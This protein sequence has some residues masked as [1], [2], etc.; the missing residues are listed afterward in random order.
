[1]KAKIELHRAGI[2]KLF[3]LLALAYGT[4]AGLS[5]DLSGNRRE[6]SE[7]GCPVPKARAIRATG[8]SELPV[9]D[10]IVEANLNLQWVV[11]G[12]VNPTLTLTRGRTYQFDLTA[13]G[14][15]H[16][17]IINSIANSQFGTVYSGPACGQVL[18]FTP[19]F[20][21]PSTIY[22]HCEVHAG[23]GGTIQLVNCSGDLNN[24]FTVNSTDFG[25]FV[26]AF[27]TNCAGCPADLNGSGSVNSTDFGLFVGAF[28]NTCNWQ[29]C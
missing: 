4:G 3:V 29:G 23:M 16:P 7:T 8:S 24:D 18:S 17:W 6:P 1:M 14:D 13:F 2:G 21:M 22:Y 19:T 27:G 9:A 5:N 12:V 11:N 25:L 20:I 15:E 10:F 26:G 28:G